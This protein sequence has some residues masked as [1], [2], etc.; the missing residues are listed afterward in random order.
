MKSPSMTYFLLSSQRSGSSLLCDLLTKTGI[1]GQ[2]AEYFMHWRGFSHEG[3]E[4]S[5]YP[6]YIQRIFDETMSP[7]GV[8]GAK[9]M[10]GKVGG[11]E[12]VIEKLEAFPIF[13]KLT[14]TEKVR[15]LFPNLKCLF[16]TRR[17]KIAQ[18]V[19]WW[20]AAQSDHY[21]STT[22]RG[23]PDSPLRYDF[24][25][26]DH[27]IS[28]IMVQEAAHQAFLDEMGLIPY[29][30]IYEDFIRDMQG[31]INA[32]IEFLGIKD[33]YSFQASN[34][35]K[36]QDAISDEWIQ[37]YRHDKQANWEHIRW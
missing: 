19:S 37:Q 35:V 14:S 30:I 28:E 21:H 10:G 17:N 29:T 8:W 3:W 9:L 32:I 15:T 11:I 23:M 7:N 1:T 12:G 5:D 24:A 27:L 33:S 25:A 26:I 18:A 20:K 16:L 4:F 6:A 13:Q 36:M 34:L 2:P 22:E 31:T